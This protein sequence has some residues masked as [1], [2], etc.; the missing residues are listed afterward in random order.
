LASLSV[1]GGRDDLSGVVG[2]SDMHL[3]GDLIEV[4]SIGMHIVFGQR[5]DSIEGL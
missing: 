1:S 2:I 5:Q 4:S 3:F